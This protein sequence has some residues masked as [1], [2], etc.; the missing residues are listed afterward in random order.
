MLDLGLVTAF[1]DWKGSP[2]AILQES[3]DNFDQ[4]NCCRGVAMCNRCSKMCQ[5]ISRTCTREEEHSLLNTYAT[6]V[7]VGCEL[8]GPDMAPVQYPAWLFPSITPTLPAYLLHTSG[9]MGEPKP[10]LVPHCCIVPNVV[11]LRERFGVNRNRDVVFNAAPL[12]F[13][14]SVVEV[15]ALLGFH[16]IKTVSLEGGEGGLLPDTVFGK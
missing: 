7:K 3:C 16:D 12:T 9:T 13:D 6:E 10:I 11:D 5:E 1:M 8:C 14:P 15:G 2:S 4:S